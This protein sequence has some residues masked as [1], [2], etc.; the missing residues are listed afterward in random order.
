MKNVW[1]IYFHSP[2]W[3][4]IIAYEVSIVSIYPI[5]GADQCDLL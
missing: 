5:T 3:V 1:N 4:A 2:V